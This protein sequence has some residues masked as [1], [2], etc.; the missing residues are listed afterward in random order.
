[1][2]SR[3]SSV[4]LSLSK[5]EPR[6]WLTLRQAQGDNDDGGGRF[7]DMVA[8]VVFLVMLVVPA[9]LAAAGFARPDTAF[10][11]TREQR[12]PFVAPA[13]S[14]GAL[15]TG[16]YERDLERQIAD[17]FPLRTTLIEAY[18]YA[19]FAWLGASTSANVIRGRDGWLFL[20][21]E[22]SRYVTGEWTPSA[23]ELAHIADVYAARARWCR[24]HGV[25][26]V[27]VIAPNKSTISPDLAPPWYRP[28]A[29][30]PLDRLLPML[31]DAGVTTIDVRAQLH[32]A[33]RRREVYSRGDTHWNDA[34]AYIAYRAVVGA[35]GAA[36]VRDAVV[37]S[38]TRFVSQAGDLLNFS[39][40]GG[41][42]MDR[43]LVLDYLKR[44]HPAAAP[45][46]ERA[47]AAKEFSLQAS[48]VDAPLPVAVVFG[49]SFVNRLAPFL[50]EDFR[51]TVVLQ[52][53]TPLAPQFDPALVLAAHANFVVQEL[54]ER[55]FVFG[56]SF[57]DD[58]PSR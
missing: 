48:A 23:A 16:G 30:T 57:R 55:N 49:D 26:Y 28:S 24:A 35:L 58:V 47:A 44:A 51:S 50:A 54:V 36:G 42:I 34:G 17:A 38:G 19:K 9:L 53:G 6:S 32:D 5:H 10:I 13:V 41:R 8:I 46:L 11:E 52:E 15:A 39:G 18:D 22:E 14:S 1:M 27:F 43:L 2:L 4:M 25:A 31:R 7:G 3:L 33:A 40:V 29:P 45:E 20:G 56:T 12:Y 21:A 37:P